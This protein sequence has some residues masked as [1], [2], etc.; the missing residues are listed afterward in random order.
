MPFLLD[1]CNYAIIVSSQKI[2]SMM[3][4]IPYG[5][6]EVGSD[7]ELMCT[8]PYGSTDEITEEPI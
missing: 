6:G 8:V 1:Q 7:E 5:K 4:S 2:R 3:D